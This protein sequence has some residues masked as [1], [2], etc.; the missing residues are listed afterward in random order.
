M[1]VKPMLY[2]AR[3][4]AMLALLLFSGSPA[5]GEDDFCGIGVALKLA[6]KRV[7]VDTVLPGGGASKADVPVGALITHV[8]G[9]SIR[10]RALPDVVEM[11]RGPEG[12]SVRLT[13]LQDLGLTREYTVSRSS[14]RRPDENTV[15]GVYTLQDAPATVVTIDRSDGGLFTVRCP[16]QHWEGVGRVGNG[17]LKGIFKMGNNPEVHENF[18]GAI[19]FFRIDFQYG[20]TLLFRSKFNFFESGDRMVEK[21][22]LRKA[23]TDGP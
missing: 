11:I 22:L 15:A 17:C 16:D 21:T 3:A 1:K 14:I 8:D 18:R 12:T 5:R 19:S 4:W 10:G 7:R 23:K 6:G 20:G 9:I 13:T 2:H